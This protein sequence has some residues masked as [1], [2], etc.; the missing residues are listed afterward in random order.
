MLLRRELRG[1]GVQGHVKLRRPDWLRGRQW[2]SAKKR[3]A[4]IVAAK[5]IKKRREGNGHEQEGIGRGKP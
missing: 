3:A 2:R 5:D 1:Q 4:L